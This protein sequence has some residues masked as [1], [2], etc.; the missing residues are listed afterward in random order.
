MKPV[1]SIQCSVFS[2][3]GRKRLTSSLT[4]HASLP[5]P[6]TPYSA[7]R[8][9]FT[10]IELMIVIGIMAIIMGMGV[11][12]IY[13][14]FHKEGLTKAVND[15][16]EVLGT[17]RRMAILQGTMT[18]VVIHPKELRLEVAGGGGGAGHAA[19]AAG[20]NPVPAPAE[21]GLSAQLSD[22]VIIEMLD[23]NM[24][25]VEY[26]DA[27]MVRVRFYPNGTSDEL[28]MVVGDESKQFGIELEVTTGLATAVPD[29]LRQWAR[30][31]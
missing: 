28:K 8:T 22:H 19:D 23:V 10:L 13:R 30:S 7:L 12:M 25:G 29:P 15:I 26:R 14:V 6:R 2:A 16:E 24:S 21:S 3:S 27:E 4:N 31:R 17:A 18:E 11:P 9:G 1:F 20:E 5:R